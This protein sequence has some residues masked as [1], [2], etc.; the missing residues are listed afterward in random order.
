MNKSLAAPSI[1][2]NLMDISALLFAILLDFLLMSTITQRYRTSGPFRPNSK[3]TFLAV[4]KAT[5]T[6]KKCH[7]LDACMNGSILPALSVL[8][9]ATKF[10]MTLANTNLVAPFSWAMGRSLLCYWF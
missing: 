6:G 3:W 10:M 2:P 4:A 9:Q 8:S 1:V 7:Q 5:S